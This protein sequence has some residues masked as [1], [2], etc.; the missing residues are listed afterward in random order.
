MIPISQR[1]ARVARNFTSSLHPVLERIYLARGI[2]EDAQLRL[3]LSELLPPEQL[4][5]I[6]RACALLIEMLEKRAPIL[7]VGDFDADGATS[8]ALAVSGLRAMGFPK[9][10]HLVP[11]RFDYGYGLS[12]EIVDVA[13]QR[14]P[15]LIVTVDNG[16]SSHAGVRRAHELGIKVL[17]TDHHLPGATLP[18]A[19]CILNPNQ[20][21]CPFP[22]KALAGV[23]V[24]FYLL[25]ALRSRLREHGWFRSQG[26]AE[27]KLADFLDLV[28]LGTVADVVPLDQNNRRL[29]RHGLQ[30]IRTG[31]CRPGVRALLEVG[32]RNPANVVAADLGFAA[33]PR[34]N[35]AGRLDDMSLG[36]A[37]LLAQDEATARR[38]ALQL[39]ALNQ[40]RRQI[41][42]EM[43]SEA[44]ALLNM[45]FAGVQERRSICLFDPNWHQ[46]VIGI[47]AGRL[48]E[49]LHRP[50]IVFAS[51]DNGEL[52][53]SGR[54]IAGIHLRDVLDRVASSWPGLLSKFGGH[55]MAAGLSLARDKFEQF[56]EA[57]EQTLRVE[58]AEELFAPRR[59]CDGA[60]T[61]DCFTLEFAELLRDAGPWG[62][63]FPEPV[64][65]NGFQVLSRRVLNDK[66]LKLTLGVPGTGTLVD[67]IAFNQ[68]PEVLADTRE[69]VSLLYRLDIN[70]FRGQRQVQLNID[71]LSYLDQ[72]FA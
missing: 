59:Y 67:G 22:S 65:H 62:Q 43:Q 21:G 9:V 69:N 53:G 2:G 25:A 46:G 29:V 10:D 35:A 12:P 33:G 23:G 47:L 44:L 55:A 72:P 32:R 3:D 20:P 56:R 36:I 71:H 51:A 28:A 15:A 24:M 30:L 37:C 38:L 17:V 54:S 49:R 57:F 68:E 70:E 5:N 48:K 52:K 66:H 39:D 13:A 41:E 6:D 42:Q 40:D 19:D 45:E 8:A 58:V 14:R 7:I 63:H 1:E 16:I 18:D 61:P 26:I 27:P 11:N 50:V 64:F 4:L 34:L 31:R 60:L